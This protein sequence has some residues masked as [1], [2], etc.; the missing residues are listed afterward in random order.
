MF[1]QIVAGLVGAIVGVS[2][3]TAYRLGKLTTEVKDHNKKLDT[4]KTD[5]KGCKRAIRLYQKRQGGK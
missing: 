2:T 1:E 3:F 4:I 5:V